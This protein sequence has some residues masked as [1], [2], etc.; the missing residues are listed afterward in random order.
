[1]CYVL[2]VMCNVLS[3]YYF[4]ISGLEGLVTTNAQRIVL[5]IVPKCILS[6]LR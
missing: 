1:M 4:K 5:E 2:C 6:T 3:D